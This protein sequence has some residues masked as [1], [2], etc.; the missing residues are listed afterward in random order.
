[1]AEP[2][3]HQVSDLSELITKARAGFNVESRAQWY[4]R[5]PKIVLGTGRRCN[6]PFRVFGS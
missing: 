5:L 3:F 4:P 2:L 6:Q 1:M